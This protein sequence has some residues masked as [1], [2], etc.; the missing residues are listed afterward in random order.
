MIFIWF[1]LRF[2]YW[3]VPDIETT[4]VEESQYGEEGPAKKHAHVATDTTEQVTL[5]Q[6]IQNFENFPLK[7]YL[8]IGVVLRP[9]L[10]SYG[11][12]I[13]KYLQNIIF[14]C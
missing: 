11:I 10:Q 9:S 8:V 5:G 6:Q 14:R 2:E 13:E 3:P 1:R 4:L 7:V 12:D